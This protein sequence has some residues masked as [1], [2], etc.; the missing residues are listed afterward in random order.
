MEERKKMSK[1]KI[2]D[3]VVVTGMDGPFNINGRAGVIIVDDGDNHPG[4]RFNKKDKDFHTC[5]GTCP[6]GYGWFVYEKD[7]KFDAGG[8]PNDLC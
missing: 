7:L 6:E 4:V 2:G 1:F 5:D 3:K 8:D